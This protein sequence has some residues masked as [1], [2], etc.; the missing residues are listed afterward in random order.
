MFIYVL[1]VTLVVSIAIVKAH[2]SE[3]DLHIP[4]KKNINDDLKINYVSA[5]LLTNIHEKR[6][7][8]DQSRRLKVR[9]CGKIEEPASDTDFFC[10]CRGCDCYCITCGSKSSNDC[11]SGRGECCEDLNV[12]PNVANYTKDIIMKAYAKKLA[13][14]KKGK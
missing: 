3:N 12:E 10:G 4:K 6:E 9:T 2:S 5:E 11:C 13:K 1:I 8:P 7:M 14:K